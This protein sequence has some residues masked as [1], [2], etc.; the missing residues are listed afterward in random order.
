[1]K[2]DQ[3]IVIL[4][5]VDR[6]NI[7]AIRE[8]H[9]HMATHGKTY[10]ALE[11]T[12]GKAQR[13]K[14]WISGAGVNILMSRVF[15][16]GSRSPEDQF[17]FSMAIALGCYDFYKTYAGDGVSVKWPNDIYWR[18]RKAGGILVENLVQGKEWKWAIAGIGLNINQTEFDPSISRTPVS[19]RQITG[20][21]FELIEMVKDLCSCLD[22][23]WQQL[24]TDPPSL[25][26]SYNE[27]LFSR[28]RS[29]KLKKGNR[30]FE[31]LIMGV[32]EYGRLVV[33]TAIE[34]RFRHG[35]IEFT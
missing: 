12:A 31:A 1:M 28:G 23:R 6:T 34:E 15:D 30:A 19:L 2:P 24:Q 21:A 26:G 22:L 9:A 7:Y 27:A 14:H 10:F 20:R 3:D 17:S 33:R 18:D 4:P 32:D 5:T 16:M 25:L 35:E 8:I 11:Q 29:V 13:G